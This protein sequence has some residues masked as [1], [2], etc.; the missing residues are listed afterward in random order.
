M[1]R[2][3]H[4]LGLFLICI[5]YAYG[6]VPQG[7]NYQAILRDGSG[8]IL[9][10][11]SIAVIVT[12]L[13]GSANGTE[14]FTETHSSS[15][16]SFGLI[17]LEIGSVNTTD[18]ESINWAIGPYFIKI[19]VNGTEFS[20]TQLLSV[21]YALHS[22]KAENVFT[23]DYNDLSNTPTN[24]SALT[25]DAGYITSFTETDPLFTESEAA[26]ITTNDITNLSNLSGT[27]TGD[28]DLSLLALKSNVLELDNTTPFTPDADYE[29]ATKKYVDAL[30]QRINELE[31]QP[32]IVKD[33]DG[34]LYTTVKIG[35]QVWIA[36]NLKTTHYANGD[37]I[38][39]GTGAGDISGETDPEYWFAYNDDLNNV[40]T[41]GRLYTWYTVT[42]PRN[43]CPDGWHVPSFAEWTQLTD[44]LG[45]NSV[46]GGKMK[47]T[48]TSHWNSPNTTATNESGFTALPAG[49]RNYWGVFG[50][51]G[52]YGNWWTSTEAN[53][54][55]AWFRYLYYDNAN[56]S[57][58][59]NDK[60]SGYSVRCLRD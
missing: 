50:S 42:D 36:E 49:S 9:A 6:Q 14:V 58:N 53:A 60:E 59:Y 45:G 34:N 12:I 3:I 1:K 55:D 21:P 43:V 15:T 27:N 56:E 29:P 41:Y 23:G 48:G 2:L 17:T 32:G 33:Y 11:Q 51:I 39:D 20:T 25:N 13:Q 16:N 30:L 35:N 10:D 40:S 28:Q 47:E 5:I 19:N 57:W 26:N 18:F 31:S 44:Y 52:N 46:A 8:N 24:V 7:F 4:S 37:A 54:T 38:P 22:K